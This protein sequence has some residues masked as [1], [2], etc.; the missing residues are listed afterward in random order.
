VLTCVSEYGNTRLATKSSAFR[1]SSRKYPDSV[2]ANWLV[3]DLVTAFTWIPLVRPCVASKRL[4]M[5]SSSAIASRLNRGC[6]LPLDD[7]TSLTCCPS[8]FNW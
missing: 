4:V 5:S 8:T 2:P 7:R 6:A 1:L 3:P